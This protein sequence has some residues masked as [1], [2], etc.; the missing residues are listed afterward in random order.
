MRIEPLP[1]IKK[2]LL[3]CEQNFVASVSLCHLGIDDRQ[4]IALAHM[5]RNCQLREIQLNHNEIQDAGGCAIADALVNHPTVVVLE[6]FQN[7]IGQ[8]GAL[9]FGRMLRTNLTLERLKLGDNNIADH[10]SEIAEAMQTNRTLCQLHIGGNRLGPMGALLLARGLRGNGVLT[11]LGLRH[12]NIGPNGASAIAELL[13]DPSCTIVD[14]QFKGNAIQSLGALHIAKAIKLNTSLKVLEL[15]ANGLGP[16]AV[17]A[18]ADALRSNHSIRALNFNENEIGDEGCAVISRLLLENAT[19]TTVGLAS[20]S[21]FAPGAVALSE[22]LLRSTSMIGLDLGRNQVG[23]QGAIAIANAI[24]HN[25]TL[26]SLD[27][28]NNFIL[29]AGSCALADMIASNKALRH[30]DLGANQARNAGA[31]A[32]GHALTLNG[33][34]TRLCLTDNMITDEGGR[35]LAQGLQFNRSLRA[36]S[37][38]GQGPNANR[39]NPQLR[40]II[41]AGISRNKQIPLPSMPV[42]PTP[43]LYPTPPP[44]S[45]E[46][47]MIQSAWSAPA[48]IKQLNP[49][50][51]I[52]PLPSTGMSSSEALPPPISPV[53]NFLEKLPPAWRRPPQT[54][55][56]NGVS[57]PCTAG[58]AASLEPY[59]KEPGFPLNINAEP[60]LPSQKQQAFPFTPHPPPGLLGPLRYGER[61]L[62][63]EAVTRRVGAIV[64]GGLQ[65]R[66]FPIPQP[67]AESSSSGLWLSQAAPNSLAQLPRETQAHFPQL[68]S[69]RAQGEYLLCSPPFRHLPLLDPLASPSRPLPIDAD[70]GS[71]LHALLTNGELPPS[72]HSAAFPAS[73][74]EDERC[75]EPMDLLLRNFPYFQGLPPSSNPQLSKSVWATEESF[76]TS[77][78]PLRV[79]PSVFVSGGQLQSGSS[80]PEPKSNSTSPLSRVS[81]SSLDSHDSIDF[82]DFLR[83]SL[84]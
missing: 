78:P 36:L 23:N 32:W 58:S 15:Q 70:H 49:P 2:I 84:A 41:D 1:T 83:S 25:E 75:E 50:K 35:S 54:P 68:E 66:L 71:V 48:G 20:N 10:V 30:L 40:R 33:T 63:L 67:T 26:T 72:G 12:N 18:L 31:S 65:E 51:M 17:I 24:R 79:E 22:A 52:T 64:S 60:F 8:E 74:S 7:Q 29:S 55:I 5:I 82:A 76:F 57:P 9:A 61:D 81:S 45:P 11:S 73:A 28:S 59:V 56:T 39:I 4:A 46:G 80:C 47:G 77:A 16:S 34:L 53:S 43:P 21:I 27:L 44:R 37:Y 14:V 42:A 19:I 62:T 13:M 38:G 6:V 3:R 69:A